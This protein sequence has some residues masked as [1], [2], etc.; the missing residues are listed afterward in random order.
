MT[1]PLH[2]TTV[3]GIRLSAICTRHQFTKDPRPA[4]DELIEAA[5]DRGDIL[6]REAGTWAGFHEGDEDRAPLVQALLGIPGAQQWAEAGRATRDAGQHRTI[7]PQ[8]PSP[9]R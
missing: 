2:P 9:P 7:D 4:I 6:A 3:L 8:R 5:A 1:G